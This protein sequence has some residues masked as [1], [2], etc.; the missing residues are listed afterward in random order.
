[1]RT[2]QIALLATIG[3]TGKFIRGAQV[4]SARALEALRLVVLEDYGRLG[5]D[6]RERWFVRITEA[7]RSELKA[8]RRMRPE[9]LT[10]AGVT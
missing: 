5:R 9:D 6:S 4:H 8:I 10:K 3:P 1:M 7:G 2:A